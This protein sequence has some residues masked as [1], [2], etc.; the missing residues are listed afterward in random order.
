MGRLSWT[1]VGDAI[2]GSSHNNKGPATP[3]PW[4]KVGGIC[5]VI[6]AQSITETI[7][8]PFVGFMVADLGVAPTKAE[9]GYYAGYLASAYFLAQFCS[10]FLWGI[11]ADKWGRR[12]VLLIGLLGSVVATTMFGFSFSYWWALVARAFAGLINANVPTAKSYL[13]DISDHTNRSRC[14]SFFGMMYGVGCILGPAIGGLTSQPAT[15]YPYLFSPEGLFGKFPY[16]LPC[17]I[18]AGLTLTGLISGQAEEV[19]EEKS[20]DGTGD[21][22]QNET[23]TLLEEG[24]E[25]NEGEVE[26]EEE[27][28]QKRVKVKEIEEDGNTDCCLSF[29]PRW[30]WSSQ[31]FSPSD[32]SSI[33]DNALLQEYGFSRHGP[34]CRPLC[35]LASAIRKYSV[36]ISAIGVY[37]LICMVYIT[38]DE[39]LPLW[40]LADR[41]SG[42]LS[43]DSSQNGT[44]LLFGGIALII[45]QLFL[46]TRLTGR[47]GVLPVM[48]VGL[49]GGSLII[50]L[51]PMAKLFLH[52]I[53]GDNASSGVDDDH[54]P[55]VFFYLAGLVILRNC[56]STMCFTSSNIFVN[57]SAKECTGKVNG[58]AFTLAGLLK[59]VGPVIGSNLLAWSLT[60]GLPFP[61]DYHF[62]FLVVSAVSLAGLFVSFGIPSQ[63]EHDD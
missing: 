60:N 14:F 18:N 3:L 17:L 40:A 29:P 52:L 51:F 49:I 12:P 43:F 6:G 1:C 23:N 38:F 55:F 48:R 28:A 31:K 15:K 42:G 21:N 5:V 2:L 11:A 35:L 22:E 47:F 25:S 56:A 53:E 16:L 62:V 8:F 33:E 54:N 45:F 9:V 57:L 7:L 39:V 10:G 59:A 32:P 61:F 37:M 20:K 41:D 34:L 44:V 26:D 46:Y 63:L 58:L 4:R 24:E 50:P 13:G 36:V 19:T 27:K 30:R